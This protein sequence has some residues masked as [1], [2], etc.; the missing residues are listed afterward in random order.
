MA[1]DVTPQNSRRHHLGARRHAG[2]SGC[3][4][5]AMPRALAHH[6]CITSI[7]HCHKAP[8]P[9]CSPAIRDMQVQGLTQPRVAARLCT[10]PHVTPHCRHQWT[11]QPLRRQPRAASNPLQQAGGQGPPEQSQGSQLEQQQQPGQQQHEQPSVAAPLPPPPPAAPVAAAAAAV[12]QQPAR[13][14]HLPLIVTLLVVTGEAVRQLHDAAAA[15]PLHAGARQLAPDRRRC[16]R[17]LAPPLRTADRAAAA[18]RC[19]P[20][21]LRPALQSRRSAIACC[22]RRPPCRWPTTCSFWRSCRRSGTLVRVCS[23]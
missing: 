3:P 20:V 5:G 22:T 18:D 15:Q 10:R 4:E 23:V 11:A 21:T 12:V 7:G 9:A 2:R 17:P 1:S 6:H 19:P 16:R 13:R 14:R 8:Q